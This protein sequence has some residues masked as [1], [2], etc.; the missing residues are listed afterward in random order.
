MD[1]NTTFC[2][3][4]L[5]TLARE[6]LKSLGLGVFKDSQLWAHPADRRGRR[7]VEF[8]GPDNFYHADYYSNAYEGRY[9]GW[10]AYLQQREGEGRN[11]G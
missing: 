6:D 7:W 11:R 2:R 5:F 3:I 9:E 4:L 8:W 10:E 1:E